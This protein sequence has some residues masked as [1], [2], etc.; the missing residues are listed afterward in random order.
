M[1]VTPYILPGLM[2]NGRRKK[3]IRGITAACFVAGMAFLLPRL[4]WQRPGASVSLDGLPSESCHVYEGIDG[5][6]LVSVPEHGYMG[7]YVVD[8]F[9]SYLRRPSVGLPNPIGYETL[10]GCV[11]SY[12]APILLYDYMPGVKAEVDP[13]LV[14]HRSDF[15]FT[16]LNQKRVRVTL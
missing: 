2:Q 8:R 15:E 13:K 1:G 14:L 12:Y 16:S 3:V 11:F 5:R 10:P 7:G 6:Y 4:W 9:N